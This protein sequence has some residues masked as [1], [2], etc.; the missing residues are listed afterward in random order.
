[1]ENIELTMWS[2]LL[3]IIRKN[4]D[5]TAI[6][7]GN[8]SINY[9]KLLARSESYVLALHKKGVKKGDYLV[10]RMSFSSDF[11]YL[12]LASIRLG[13][14]FIPLSPEEKLDKFMMQSGPDKI[15]M[16]FCSIDTYDKSLLK[17]LSSIEIEEVVLFSYDVQKDS[18]LEN[19]F[20]N[21]G[22]NIISGTSFAVSGLYYDPYYSDVLS[23]ILPFENVSL[24]DVLMCIYDRECKLFVP[25]TGNDLMDMC[26]INSECGLGKVLCYYSKSSI[27]G[28]VDGII[29]PILNG[30]TIICESMVNKNLLSYSLLLNK[31]NTIYCGIEHWY[32]ICYELS[33]VKQVKK[34][35]CPQLKK[36]K[37]TEGLLPREKSFF[38]KI[39]RDHRFGCANYSGGNLK[40]RSF[41]VGTRQEPKSISIEELGNCEYPLSLLEKYILE[42]SDEV[43]S[44]SVFL[45]DELNK[46]VVLI[47]I[48]LSFLG[49]RSE[50]ER[51]LK[52]I[53][54]KL[55]DTLP[56][57][58][59][60]SIYFLVNQ[61]AYGQIK[62]YRNLDKENLKK[63]SLDVLL[64]YREIEE[65]VKS[66]AKTFML[67][68]K[69][70]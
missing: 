31:P 33:T 62:A 57:E 41:E 19:H 28:I 12:L 30:A 13:C 67:A 46:K 18:S 3:S 52:D 37:I 25:Y 64:S 65:W 43:L 9:L 4:S 61:M 5:K 55:N 39:A 51:I 66:D 17:E 56:D 16:L 2:Q 54:I 45:G 53:V 42:S 21:S 60:D 1:M 58:L 47:D 50:D 29:N 35:I 11:I 8:H 38:K 23:C 59:K 32:K 20:A 27:L 69:N 44:A 70:I 10:T 22:R 34:A 36:V 15:K 6:E 7:Y 63:E 48:E 14:I 26:V 40:I 49:E 24:N 68:F